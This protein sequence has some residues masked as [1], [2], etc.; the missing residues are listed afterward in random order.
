MLPNPKYTGGSPASRN[1][2]TSSG[3]GRESGRIQAPVWTTPAGPG[4]GASAASAA[5]HG[6]S[7]KTWLCSSSTGAS[8]DATRCAFSVGPNVAFR[9]RAS[10]AHR[11]RG[12]SADRHGIGGGECRSDGSVMGQKLA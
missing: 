12:V 4:Q 3:N 11:A 2:R 8:P 9:C 5:S 6:R 10:S 1:S 7:V